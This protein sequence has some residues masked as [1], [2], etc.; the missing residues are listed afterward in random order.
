M[1]TPE[2]RLIDQKIHESVEKACQ[3]LM[4]DGPR[5]HLGASVI[6]HN[7][8]AHLWLH[9]RHA[10]RELF[11]G[12]MLRLFDR[13]QMEEARVMRWLQAAGWMMLDA[14]ARFSECN[15]HFGGSCD[16]ILKPPPD[17]GLPERILWECKTFKDGSDYK[18]LWTDRNLMI[19]NKKH[20]SQM[21]LYGCAFGLEYGLY[22]A[23]NKNNDEI[24]YEIVKLDHTFA[25][26]LVEKA[27][28]IIESNEKPLG[29]ASSKA[30]YE[31][32]NC[33]FSGICHDSEKP[34]MNCRSCRFASA[35]EGGNWKCEKF[36]IIPTK[37][38]KDGCGNWESCIN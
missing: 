16:G 37:N 32:K 15:G 30:Y 1:S 23:V 5:K 25:K 21:C 7:C 3:D 20:Y 12:R 11:S 29:I 36:G 28:S 14:Q 31:C 17:L 19:S 8:K 35:V 2:T 22:T 18:K 6:G 13:G 10:K 26:S 9:F 34:E 33:V 4:Q 27:A 38:V 24:Y